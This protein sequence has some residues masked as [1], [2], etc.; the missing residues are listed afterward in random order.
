M[1][2]VVGGVAGGV[3]GH[4]GTDANGR[5][6]S[7]DKKTSSLSSDNSVANA[8]T[9][10]N[11]RGYDAGPADG[12]MGPSTRSAI[13]KFQADNKLPQTGALDGPTIT[14]LNTK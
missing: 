8:Q 7:T 5:V 6:T 11:S 3:I 4:Q 14:A 1:G 13:M 12:V 2:A 10:L 9:T